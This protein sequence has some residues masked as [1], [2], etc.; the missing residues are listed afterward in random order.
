MLKNSRN[1]SCPSCPYKANNSRRIENHIKEV[2]EKLRPHKC[3]ECDRTF[4][5]K[6]TLLQH[7]K[8]EHQKIPKPFQC[9]ICTKGFKWKQNLDKHVLLFCPL[10]LAPFHPTSSSL[11]LGPRALRARERDYILAHSHC[12]TG[13]TSNEACERGREGGRVTRISTKFRVNVVISRVI[14]Q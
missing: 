1:N 10:L 11:G 4:F 6:P 8:Y 12:A 14:A 5:R 3:E 13:S 2:H 7:V 9:S